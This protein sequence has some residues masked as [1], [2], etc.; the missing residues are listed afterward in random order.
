M[1]LLGEWISNNGYP[2]SKGISSS[3]KFRFH[4]T[5]CSIF[6]KSHMENSGCS[7]YLDDILLRLPDVSS[8]PGDKKELVIA[9]G[10]R[11]GHHSITVVSRAAGLELEGVKIF[12]KEKT[13][14][15]IMPALGLKPSASLL[16]RMTQILDLPN[17]VPNLI[18]Q[19]EL[20]PAKAL[21][22]LSL[23]TSE[24]LALCNIFE[25][26]KPGVNLQRE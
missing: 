25:N 22:F 26:L 16:Q 7:I 21:V 17:R 5:G 13:I 6:M 9:E 8:G 3:I 15:E 20:M 18:H 11:D 10:L 19:N 14:S 24:H 4:G 12:G 23:E 2:S 1:E